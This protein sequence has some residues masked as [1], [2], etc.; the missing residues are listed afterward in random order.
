MTGGIDV[1]VLAATRTPVE[2]S[3]VRDWVRREVEPRYGSTRIV[4]LPALAAPPAAYADLGAA[5]TDPDLL[6]MPAH[7]VWRPGEKD[8]HRR[9]PLTDLL[10]ARNPYHPAAR[11]QR[12]I[13]DGDPD[14]APVIAGVPATAGFLRQRYAETHHGAAAGDEQLGRFVARRARL[15]LERADRTVLGPQFRSP[16]FLTEEILRSGRFRAGL[17][18]LAARLGPDVASEAKAQ[19]ILDELATGWGR[20][21]VDL[22]PRIDRMVFQR[23]F[24]P[25]IDVVPGE[26][27]R[28]RTTVAGLPVIFLWSHR[29]NLDTRV[30][31]VALYENGLPLPHLFAGINMAFGPMGPILRRAGTIFIRRSFGGDELYKYVLKEFVGYLTEKRFN[32]SWS[33]EGTRSRTGKMLPP[34]LGL[35]GYTAEA[36]LAGRA[37]DIMLQPVSITFDQLHEIGEYAAYARGGRKA[38]EGMA[39]LLGFIKAQGERHFG[40]I[41]VR[42]PEPVSMRSL[43]GAPGGVTTTDPQAR[44]LALQKTAFEVAWRINEATPVTSVALVTSA[45]LAAR[46]MALTTSQ[47]H[48]A[49][50]GNLDYLEQRGIP[51]V[52]SVAGLRDLDGVEATLQTLAGPGGIVT[53]VDGARDVVWHITTDD[54]LAATFYRNSIIHVFLNSGLCE[55]ALVLAAQEPPG[56]GRIEAFWRWVMELRD[57]LKFEFYFK[58]RAE[59]RRQIE[60]EVARSGADW[61]ERLAADPVDVRALLV[62]RAPLTAAFML[63][64]F[65][66]AYLIVADVVSRLDGEIDKAATI[67]EALALGEQFLAQKRIQSAEPVSALLF[68]TG[69]KVMANRGLLAAAPDREARVNAFEDELEGRVLAAIITIEDLMFSLFVRDRQRLSPSG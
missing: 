52:E 17:S 49:L 54:Q 42:F 21:A 15:G 31:N 51:V 59:F 38:A 16:G 33:I 27:D 46:G 67:T 40:K 41:Y 5:L 9:V 39:W 69:L 3:L 23:G 60:S 55:I 61:E 25:N 63:R 20:L 19:E 30:L 48:T 44:Q 1:L 66:E 58:D 64:P 22:V 6:L 43:L 53:R 32:L 29:S 45:L 50:R 18:A 68:E 65:I 28:L 57:V 36:Y 10:R 2:E 7:V 37:D 4:T 47:V 62:P 35:L 26:L 56:P 8:G 13:A 11:H 34:K 14:R 24:D 12:A